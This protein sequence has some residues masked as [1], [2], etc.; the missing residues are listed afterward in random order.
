MTQP[1]TFATRQRFELDFFIPPGDWETSFDKLEVWR[2]RATSAGP[3]DALHADSWAPAVLPAGAPATASGTGP[4][5][6]IVG[7]KVTFLVNESIPVEVIF[8]GVDP[9]TYAQAAVQVAAQSQGLLSS[10]VNGPVFVVKTVQAGVLAVLRCTG[11]DAAPLLGLATAEPGSLAFGLDARIV[12]IH[13]QEQ[14]GFV[15]PDGSP[16]FYYKLRYFNTASKLVSDFTPPFQGGGG[17]GISTANLVRCYVDLIGLS[18][19][20]AVNAE[21]LIGSSFTGL[22]VEGKTLVGGNV[23]L[24]TD[25]N[26]H[27]ELL[28]PR[29]ADVTVAIGGTTLARRFTVPLDTAIEAVN[30]LDPSIGADDLF[31]V[32]VPRLPYAVRRTI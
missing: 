19:N 30:M 26:G 17:V 10:Y 20:V 18:G 15:D 6:V 22:Q 14:Y 4:S 23:R 31:T 32:K 21:V 24:L 7:K 3:Y 1:A 28:I 8:T 12:L 25:A 16:N 27:A 13:G 9:L 5:A 2:S 29:G 11:G